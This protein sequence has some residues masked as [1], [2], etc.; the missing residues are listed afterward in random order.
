MRASRITVYFSIGLVFLC[1]VGALQ[2]NAYQATIGES[3][4]QARTCINSKGE[5][6]GEGARDGSFICRSGTWVYSP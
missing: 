2:S 5:T 3:T 4:A 1:C 6:V